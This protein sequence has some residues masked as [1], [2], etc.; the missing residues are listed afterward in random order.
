MEDDILGED[1]VIVPEV[2]MKFKDEK[3]LFEF[4]KRYAYD[5]SFQLGEGILESGRMD[6]LKSQQTIQTGCKARLTASSDIRGIRLEFLYTRVT[7]LHLLK[8]VGMRIS[9]A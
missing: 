5:V 4:Y 3:E 9:L 8:R 1:G 7:I 6:C 2:S